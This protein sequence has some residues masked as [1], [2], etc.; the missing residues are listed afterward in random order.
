MKGSISK[1]SA[2]PL[3][4]LPGWVLR[5]ARL[6]LAEVEYVDQLI[7]GNPE[8]IASKIGVQKRTVEKWQGEVIGWLK[9]DK[10]SHS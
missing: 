6:G 4:I 9:A 5:S 8:E 1:V 3:A 10:Q 7:E 2:P